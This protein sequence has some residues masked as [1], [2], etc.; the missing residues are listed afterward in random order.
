MLSVSTTQKKPNVYE[1][2]ASV[3]LS[4]LSIW[5]IQRNWMTQSSAFRRTKFSL[6]V[7]PALTVRQMSYMARTR[8]DIWHLRKHNWRQLVIR[9]E[10]HTQ[11]ETQFRNL[12]GKCEFIFEPCRMT[13]I[14]ASPL[15]SQ[16]N[17]SNHFF[18]W[19]AM[20]SWTKPTF[21]N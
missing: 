15:Q 7:V 17:T 16:L 21:V 9:F 10:V 14:C 12:F 6:L 2:R 5:S 3:W 11:R 19:N 20:N 18:D 1:V 8:I 13:K 4:M